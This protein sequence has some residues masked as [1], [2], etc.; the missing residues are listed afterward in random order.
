VER[1]NDADSRADSINF[2]SFDPR[3]FA[4]FRGNSWFY[5]VPTRLA[6]IEAAP[7][8]L[9]TIWNVKTRE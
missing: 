5:I 3:V 1:W 8:Q 2:A 6:A 4:R 7:N 9:G